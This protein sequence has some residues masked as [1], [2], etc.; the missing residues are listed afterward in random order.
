MRCEERD[1]S[2]KNIVFVLLGSLILLMIFSMTVFNSFAGKVI[3]PNK[4]KNINSNKIKYFIDT[5]KYDESTNSLIINGWMFIKGVTIKTYECH[6]VLRDNKTHNYE[7]IPTQ[8]VI[9]NDVTRFYKNP[10]NQFNYDYSG[11]QAK[12]RL[13]ELKEP[14]GEYEICLHYNNNSANVFVKT[15]IFL[16]RME[17][18]K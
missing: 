7:Q 3:T 8:L 14:L 4:F 17:V 13:N 16:K 6:V 11:F 15:G 18:I 12:L 1:I 5:Q 9:R 10:Q 2:K